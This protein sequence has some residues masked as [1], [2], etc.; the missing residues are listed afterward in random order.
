MLIISWFQFANWPP[1]PRFNAFADS[2]DEG[3][4]SGAASAPADGVTS[5]AGL[6]TATAADAFTKRLGGCVLQKTVLVFRQRR[7]KWVKRSKVFLWPPWDEQKWSL[8]AFRGGSE[9]LQT[10]LSADS[11][12][13]LASLWGSPQR[14]PDWPGTR[15]GKLWY[16]T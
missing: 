2:D 4:A 7:I 1:G 10:C 11:N 16:T 8:F 9:R 14:K 5:K 3:G 12:N 13:G 15:R 6:S